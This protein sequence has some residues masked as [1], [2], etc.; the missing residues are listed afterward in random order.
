MKKG[1][2]LLGML[3]FACS[4]LF[5]QPQ[6]P[7]GVNLDEIPGITAEQKTKVQAELTKQ[8]E[9]M[10]SFFQQGGTDDREAMMKKMEELR[11]ETNKKIAGILT[12]EQY[13][14]YAEKEAALRQRGPGGPGGQG[15]GPR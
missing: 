10:M 3:L 7:R 8:R 1:L 9:A 2:M 11:A 5:A 15:G 12:E 6:G 13:K 14:A 4:S